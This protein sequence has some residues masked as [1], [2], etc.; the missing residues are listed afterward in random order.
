MDALARRVAFRYLLARKSLAPALRMAL[1]DLKGGNNESVKKALGDFW[2]QLD[3]EEEATGDW[4]TH[5]HIKGEYYTALGPKLR[6]R[7]KR[8]LELF[9]DVRRGVRYPLSSNLVSKF[10]ALIKEAVWL[11]GVIRKGPEDELQHGDFTIIPMQGVSQSKQT[12]CLAAL[13]A[14]ASHIRSKFPHLLYGKVYLTKALGRSVANYAGTTDTISLSLRAAK[15]VGDVL[16]LCHEFGHRYYR[17]FWKDSE[18]KSLFWRLSTEPEYETTVFDRA[19][20]AK[21]ADEMLEIADR[22][23]AGA[24]PHGSELSMQYA[25]YINQHRPGQVAPLMR[26]YVYGKEDSVRKDLWDA[27]AQPSEGDIVVPTKKVIREPIHVT[28]YGGT[29]WTENFAEAFAYYVMGKDLHPEIAAIM[30][31]LH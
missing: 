11:E 3:V 12:E 4:G 20:R 5:L 6:S 18:Q 25:G 15:T 27:F 21:L 14:A 24:S 31:K 16:A 9:D 23:R 29:E 8:M 19:T 2:A 1:E 22:V 13:D 30:D 28:P 7:F 17:R 26:Q 10:E